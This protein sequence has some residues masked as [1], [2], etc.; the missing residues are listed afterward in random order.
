MHKLYRQAVAIVLI[1][2]YVPL[3]VLSDGK[4]QEMADIV[5]NMK[6]TRLCDHNCQPVI[7]ISNTNLTI[8]YETNIFSNEDTGEPSR[9]AK[10]K[11]LRID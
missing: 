4:L 9:K 6:T 11:V 2:S 10:K 3:E 1:V 7:K 5:R 8:S